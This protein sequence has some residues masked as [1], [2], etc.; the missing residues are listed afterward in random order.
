MAQCPP[1]KYAPDWSNKA[2]NSKL[3]L[4]RQGMQKTFL[5]KSNEIKRVD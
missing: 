4:I 2:S 1:P 3:S 5:N